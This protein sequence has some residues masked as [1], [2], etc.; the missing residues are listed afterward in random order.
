MGGRFKTLSNGGVPASGE[1]DGG[2][3]YWT[4]TCTVR[5]VPSDERIVAV[6]LA[7]GTTVVVVTD[8]RQRP[9]AGTLVLPNV[10]GPAGVVTSTVMVLPVTAE[11]VP[12]RSQVKRLLERA[13]TWAVAT[14][15]FS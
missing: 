11:V 14:T 15:R 9:L 1:G 7:L 2:S 12:D 13:V 6:G 4:P 8:I 10:T 5:T 3:C